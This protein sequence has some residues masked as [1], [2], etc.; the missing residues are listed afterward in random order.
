MEAYGQ[1]NDVVFVGI[2]GDNWRYDGL[3]NGDIGGYAGVANV[4]FGTD[5]ASG[6]V[7]KLSDTA[8]DSYKELEAALNE[9]VTGEHTIYFVFNK[10]G[11][12]A[13]SWKFK[14]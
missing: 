3:Y 14:K 12:L 6:I 1:C 5:G 2:V 10:L 9:T 7:M 8:S 11:V 13:D 4:D